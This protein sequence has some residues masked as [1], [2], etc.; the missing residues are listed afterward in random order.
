MNSKDRVLRI[1]N[2][3]ADMVFTSKELDWLCDTWLQMYEALEHYEIT[4]YTHDG[5][6][7]VHDDTAR[8]VLKA[9]EQGSEK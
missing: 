1:K 7:C 6:P 9:I 2:F 8:E 5:Y 3:P 4:H